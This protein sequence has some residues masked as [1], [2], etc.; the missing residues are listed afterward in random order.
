MKPRPLDVQGRGGELRRPRRGRRSGACPHRSDSVL[1][2]R[3]H[4][5]NG[6]AALDANAQ[7]ALRT[8]SS[9]LAGSPYAVEIT[10]Y[11][12]ARGSAAKNRTLAEQ[13]AKAVR[14]A[15]MATGIPPER[16]RLVP[17]GQRR[18]RH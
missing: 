16:L 5:A 9:S 6:S 1:P 10:G 2:A 11:A 17:P 18:R 4:F 3:V 15:L 12:D 8:I 13:R 7:E 14:D